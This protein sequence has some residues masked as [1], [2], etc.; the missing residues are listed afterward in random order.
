MSDARLPRIIYVVLLAIGVLDWV[1]RYPLLPERMASHF[2]PHGEVN[3]WQSKEAFFTT[4]TAVV[5]VS[6]VA[7]FV[8]PMLLAITPASMINLPNKEYWLAPERRVQTMRYV[9]MKMAWFGCGLLFLLLFVTSEAINANLPSHGQFNS[10]A[11]WVVLFGF[12]VFTAM[13]TVSLLRHF[14]RVR[15]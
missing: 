14:S 3:N 12:L 11:M 6:F 1:R 13:W 15:E 4:M 7:G 9:S 8:V 2:G 10:Q 5:G